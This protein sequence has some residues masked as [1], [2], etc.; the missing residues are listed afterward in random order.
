M[1]G[2]STELVQHYQPQLA[3]MWDHLLSQTNNRLKDCVTF[4]NLTGKVTFIDQIQETEFMEKTGRMEKT[5]LEE[6]DFAKRAIY[7]R[8]F[9]KAVG[10]DEFDEIKLSG[11]RL[12]ITE[13][14]QKMREGY[15]RRAEKVIIDALLGTAYEGENGV[16]PIELPT[17]QTIDL[18]FSYDGAGANTGLTFDKFARLRRLAMENEA[19]GQGVENGSDMLVLA[20][21]ASGIEDL[22]HDIFANHK[23]Y[24]TAIESIRQGE[25]NQFLG[26]QI[27]RTEQLP[28]RIVGNDI[29][30]DNVAWIKSRVCFG[31][32][33]NYSAKISVRDDLSEAIQLRAKAACGASRLEEE[34]VFKIPALVTS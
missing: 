22:Y 26:V 4:K 29:V 8:E 1:F 31:T 25:A 12:P 33:N 27:K 7:A 5:E 32:R 16:T 17:S 13:T 14:M 6:M 28:S 15:E 3:T 19:F 9:Q 30:R 24:V 21:T 34:A 23:E 10:F 20:T 2:T 18:N 11:Q